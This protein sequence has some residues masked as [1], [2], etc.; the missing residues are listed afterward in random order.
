MPRSLTA[1][2][3]FAGDR[4]LPNYHN[5]VKYLIR[6]FVAL[7]PQ[8]LFSA[9]HSQLIQLMHFNRFAAAGAAVRK[10]LYSVTCF[11]I[12]AIGSRMWLHMDSWP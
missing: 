3:C 9:T 10:V 8:T 11:H 6:H 7:L 1:E 4:Y 12:H 2:G 5:I